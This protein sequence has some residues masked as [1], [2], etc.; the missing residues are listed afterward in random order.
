MKISYRIHTGVFDVIFPNNGIYGIMEGGPSKVVATDVD[1]RSGRPWT[2]RH[3]KGQVICGKCV[4]R[5]D[6]VQI[7]DTLLSKSP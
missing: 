7:V 4:Q 6:S 5:K 2:W 1:E 3:I